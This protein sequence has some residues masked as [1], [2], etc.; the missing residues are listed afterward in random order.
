MA[1]G[2]NWG[3]IYCNSWWGSDSNKDSL[4]TSEFDQC[5]VAPIPEGYQFSGY[6]ELT[7]AVFLWFYDNPSAISTYGEINTWGVSAVTVMQ[8][9]FNGETTF[10]DDISN[11]D[12]SNVTNMS[13]MFDGAT[14]FNQDIS[15]WDVSSVTTM[16]STFSNANSF[17]QN[18]ASW[19]VSS[20]TNMRI[21]FRNAGVFNRDLSGWDV[22]GIINNAYEDFAT[23]TPA[24]T[25]PKPI[26]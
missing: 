7:Q 22:S 10:N 20:V 17:N 23:N 8:N 15:S 5:A 21:M 18:I 24:W 11:W 6:S 19:D 3:K 14:S 12:V 16:N 4:P 9:I 1:N 26:F 25:L 2:I 13:G